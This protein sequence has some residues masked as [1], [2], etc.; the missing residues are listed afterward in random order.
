[1]RT[2]RCIARVACAMW[3]ALWGVCL[4]VGEGEAGLRASP[5]I[6]RPPTTV[7]APAPMIQAFDFVAHA[8]EAEWRNDRGERLPF[9]GAESD[10]RGFVVVK[11]ATLEDGQTYQDVLLTHPRWAAD[12]R[13][14]GRYRLKPAPG[15][16]FNAKVGFLDGAAGTDGV[17]FE[18]LWWLGG[19]GQTLAEV[20]DLSEGSL[21]RIAVDLGQFA[22]REGE[23]E[24]RVE[25]GSSSARDWAVWVQPRIS[26]QEEGRVTVADVVVRGPRDGDKD[27][28]PDDEEHW[29]LQRYSP[30]YKFSKEGDT[31]EPYRPVD[32]MWFIRHST[33]RTRPDG[34]VAVPRGTL[35]ANP[36][37]LLEVSRGGPNLSSLAEWTRGTAYTLDLAD[38]YRAGLHRGDGLDWDE[39]QRRGNVGLYGHVAPY[40][41]YYKIEY[42]QCFGMTADLHEGG[43]EVPVQLV[44]DPAEAR[45]L[46]VLHYGRGREISFHL[47][48]ESRP[49]LVDLDQDW[50]K[51][52]AEYNVGYESDEEVVLGLGRPDVYWYGDRDGRASQTILRFRQDP[53]TGEYTHPIVYVEPGGHGMYPGEGYRCQV[54]TF[55]IPLRTPASNGR[56]YSFLTKN[57]PNL[58][59][60]DSPASDE[61]AIILLFNGRWGNGGEDASPR[62]PSL[63]WPWHW[64]LDSRIRW[65]IRRDGRD[66]DLEKPRCLGQHWP[67]VAEQSHWTMFLD[68]DSLGAG[69]VGVLIA[70]D[71]LDEMGVLSYRGDRS[72]R[73][74]AARGNFQEGD[75][76]GAG[77]VDG[78]GE[79]D[80]VYAKYGSD[81]ICWGDSRFE[82]VGGFGKWDGLAVADLDGLP[83]RRAEIIHIGRN[84]ETRV[85][86]GTGR[87]LGTFRANFEEGDAACAGDIDGDGKAEV[88]VGDFSHNIINAY[89]MAGARVAGFSLPEFEK[90][91]GL[92]AA[93]LN[94]DGICEIIH[95]ARRDAAVVYDRTGR[96]L[97]R[98]F[99]PF[100]AGDALAAGD[101]D[102]DGRGEIVFADGDCWVKV[103]SLPAEMF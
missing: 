75:R 38:D 81:E 82:A 2:P 3:V 13:I 90:W 84:N 23:L 6:T 41:T 53:S 21:R 97:V 67:A 10:A 44:Y 29:L 16:W 60:A 34:E 33:L 50:E 80:V 4:P 83:D 92:A 1:M 76:V 59:E 11:S 52:T 43:W 47:R 30:Y 96:E 77:D 20:R 40:G 100:A 71:G 22:G 5:R 45:V 61:A 74:I 94:G 25:A 19:T 103:F 36:K 7:T 86:A 63:T 64:P 66:S 55:P 54:R 89:N 26:G 98:F 79:D 78:D 68:W 95:A 70:R 17:T 12:G 8:S 51:E 57:I 99:I 42:Y 72:W 101:V 32:A 28:I 49:V 65:A 27:G 102:G 62:G 48:R 39:I 9:P 58:G 18:V 35:A 91:D 31:D 37:S 88:L 46:R 15:R 87:L 73:P 93:D 14:E 85:H 69:R 56:S 24:L